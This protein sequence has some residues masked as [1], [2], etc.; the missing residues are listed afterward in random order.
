VRQGRHGK[1]FGSAPQRRCFA[2]LGLL[3]SCPLSSALRAYISI[4]VSSGMI[5]HHPEIRILPEGLSLTTR[6]EVEVHYVSES[7]TPSP[8]PI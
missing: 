1:T 3:L 6:P 2:P 5:Y 4:D 8:P 7:G